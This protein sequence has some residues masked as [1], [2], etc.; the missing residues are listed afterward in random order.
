MVCG[1]GQVRFLLTPPGA[2]FANP[3]K[4]VIFL[5]QGQIP[6][7]VRSTCTACAGTL[8]LEFGVLSRLTGAAH[9]GHIRGHP[10]L[11]GGT[12][13]QLACNRNWA[14]VAAGLKQAVCALKQ[15]ACCGVPCRQRHVRGQGAACG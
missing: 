8:L 13:G 4:C 7:D 10:R 2:V 15:A 12:C 5:L 11:G 14:R 6:G 9:V 3:A 1:P